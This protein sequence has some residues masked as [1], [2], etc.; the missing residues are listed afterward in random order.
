MI[1]LYEFDARFLRALYIGPQLSSYLRERFLLAGTDSHAGMVA[2]AALY[3]QRFYMHHSFADVS[4]L[5]IASSCKY[6]D[7]IVIVAIFACNISKF[8]IVVQRPLSQ[9]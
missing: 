6:W 4:H 5:A 3:L 8:K 2:V 9:F 1:N 7:R